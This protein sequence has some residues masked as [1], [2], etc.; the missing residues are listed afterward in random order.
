MTWRAAVPSEAVDPG[1]V[2]P[3]ELAGADLALWRTTSGELVA[4]DARCPHQWSHLGFEGV[5]VGDEL[6]CAAHHWR[7]AVDGSGTKRS[8][9][10][11]VDPKGPVAVHPV[12]ERDGTIEIDLD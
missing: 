12:R 2:R 10:G 9:S 4:C 5:V 3:L 6:V 7:F 1:Q 8:M 11:R